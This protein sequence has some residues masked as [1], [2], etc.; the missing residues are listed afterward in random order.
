MN[1]PS[2]IVRVVTEKMFPFLLMF[3]FYIIL[4]GSSSPGGGFQ[5]GVVIGAAYILYAIGVNAAC[6]RKLA[7]YMTLKVVE[8][9]GVLMYVGIGLAGICMGYTF[10]ANRVIGFPPQGTPG[11]LLSGGTLLGINIGIGIH[12]A[13]TVITLFYAFMEYGAKEENSEEA[14]LT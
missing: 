6:G 10:L 12:V 7:P 8:S 9:A 13:A 2:L 4:H 5:G 3:G 14:D 11:S 1:K